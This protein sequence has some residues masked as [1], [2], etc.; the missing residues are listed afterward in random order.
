M[1]QYQSLHGHVIVKSKNKREKTLFTVPDVHLDLSENAELQYQKSESLV[2]WG[3]KVSPYAV[4]VPAHEAEDRMRLGLPSTSLI[5]NLDGDKL[6]NTA[7]KYEGIHTETA[8]ISLGHSPFPSH[9]EDGKD[10]CAINYLHAGCEKFWCVVAPENQE[11]YE[12]L[13]RD[14]C[15]KKGNGCSQFVRHESIFVYTSLLKEHGISFT[16]ARQTPHEL[17]FIFEGAYH[18]GYNNGPNLAE[19]VNYLPGS[20]DVQNYRSCYQGCGH[21]YDTCLPIPIEGLLPAPSPSSGSSPPSMSSSSSGSSPSSMS[22]SSS[23]SNTLP[24][25]NLPSRK[26]SS[27]STHHH[28]FTSKRVRVNSGGPSP[29]ILTGSSRSAKSFRTAK[30]SGSRPLNESISKILKSGSRYEKTSMEN[31][32]WGVEFGKS[33]GTESMLLILWHYIRTYETSTIGS[34][35]LVDRTLSHDLA[36]LWRSTNLEKQHLGSLENRLQ[37]EQYSRRYF[38][39]LQSIGKQDLRCDTIR[40]SPTA[41]KILKEKLEIRGKSG[42]PTGNHEFKAAQI[43]ARAAKI[44]TDIIAIFEPDLGNHAIVAIHGTRESTSRYVP[45]P[46]PKTSVLLSLLR[47]LF[48]ELKGCRSMNAKHF[49]IP[50]EHARSRY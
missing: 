34:K 12:K 1:R 19:A 46:L 18:Q 21:D 49:L 11:K 42:D 30:L 28:S 31:S 36:S 35:P 4:D 3:R 7:E 5:Y 13:V 24:A 2:A 48:S 9:I 22:S 44:W 6:S 26:R 41:Q 14:L 50:Y 27:R 16:L 17:M 15:N 38:K 32:N 37:R 39:E 47:I 40:L 10:I 25:S 43:I 29:P 23:V 20:L 8:Y 45:R 33:F